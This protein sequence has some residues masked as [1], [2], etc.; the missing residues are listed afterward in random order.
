MK[1]YTITTRFIY[2]ICYY[3]VVD[4]A[5][6]CI[7]SYLVATLV[8]RQTRLS[9]GALPRTHLPLKDV[10]GFYLAPV[11]LE[12]PGKSGDSFVRDAWFW[13]PT[14]LASDRLS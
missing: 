13:K 12:F 11:P 9:V 14:I 3:T 6:I 1:D 8:L 7:Q 10:S 5:R 2:N 4:A